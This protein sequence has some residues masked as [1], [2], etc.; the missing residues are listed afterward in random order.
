[1]RKHDDK[2]QV[3]ETITELRDD[4]LTMQVDGT[5][6][7]AVAGLRDCRVQP[8]GATPRP[9][10]NPDVDNPHSFYDDWQLLPNQ[11]DYENAFK[12]QW[13]LFLRHVALDEP[14]RWTL[15]EGARGVQLAE[16]GMR[17]WREKRWVDVG[18]LGL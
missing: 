2:M 12:V 7:S 8:Y 13:E 4:L 5:R 15:M 11:R 6:G 14:F 17:S 10:W 9:T 3:P 1:M 18:D 16:L